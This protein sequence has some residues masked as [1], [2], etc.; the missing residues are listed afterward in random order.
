MPEVQKQRSRG[1]PEA[2]VE[3]RFGGAHLEYWDE[4]RSVKMDS[5]DTEWA[6]KEKSFKILVSLW[7]ARL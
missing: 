7:Q 5:Q 3:R 6:S 2:G 4:E 1:V